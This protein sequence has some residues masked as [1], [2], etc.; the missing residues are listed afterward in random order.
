MKLSKLVDPTFQTA[1]KKLSTQDI[2]FRSAFKL[3]GM[4]KQVNEALA[5]YEN[6]RVDALKRF[7]EKD[8]KGELVVAEGGSVKLSE[9]NA[10]GFVKELQDLLNDN[11]DIGSL[12]VADLGDKL[13][14]S[15]AEL[16][17]LED[18]LLD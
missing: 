7:G 4:I 6:V 5:D 16:M 14:M 10:Q 17:A 8:D 12:K 2:P 11:I 3:K 18:I 1:L 15:A 9:E 13:S